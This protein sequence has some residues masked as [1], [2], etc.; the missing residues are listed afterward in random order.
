MPWPNWSRWRARSRHKRKKIVVV[1][2]RSGKA[3]WLSLG[4]CDEAIHSALGIS[5]L[6]CPHRRRHASHCLTRNDRAQGWC[7]AALSQSTRARREAAHQLRSVWDPPLSFVAEIANDSPAPHIRRTCWRRNARHCG[8]HFRSRGWSVVQISRT[9]PS[10]VNANAVV[11]QMKS[12][13]TSAHSF[14]LD[15]MPNNTLNEWLAALRD[16]RTR[17]RLTKYHSKRA[18]NACRR[19]AHRGRRLESPHMSGR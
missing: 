14:V 10:A 7:A 1:F 18:S 3:N 6:L 9:P 17:G 5:R 13:L 12:A 11:P 2:A 16:P 19:R 4:P 15:P 8:G